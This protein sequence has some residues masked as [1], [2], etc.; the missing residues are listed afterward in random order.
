[1]KK[2]ANGGQGIWL[3][4]L[5]KV[6]REDNV[7]RIRAIIQNDE[8]LFLPTDAKVRKKRQINEQDWLDYVRLSSEHLRL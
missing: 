2:T 8:H 1:M 4:A 6:P 5:Y 3:E 7:K